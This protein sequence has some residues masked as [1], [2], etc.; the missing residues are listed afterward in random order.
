MRVGNG[1]PRRLLPRVDAD[2]ASE[3]FAFCEAE[4]TF[5]RKFGASVRLGKLLAL[6][7]HRLL[8]HK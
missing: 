8:K 5:K 2:Q 7:S 4:L 1:Y 3:E 6:S